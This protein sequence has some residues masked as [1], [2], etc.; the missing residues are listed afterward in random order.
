MR[1]LT[2]IKAVRAYCIE[3]S[4][5]DRVEVK[6]CEMVDCPLWPYR[7]GHRPKKNPDH[8]AAQA[9]KDALLPS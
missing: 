5:F 2:P 1:L 7:M 8:G 6:G 9:A 4:G 3:C